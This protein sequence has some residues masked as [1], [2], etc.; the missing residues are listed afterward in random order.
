MKANLVPCRH[1]QRRFAPDRVRVHERACK[2]DRKPPT[3]TR[4]DQDDIRMRGK[5]FK[6]PASYIFSSLLNVDPIIIADFGV[7]FA[8]N[9]GQF[10]RVVISVIL[11]LCTSAAARGPQTSSSM[12]DSSLPRS[13]GTEMSRSMPATMTTRQQQRVPKFV[14]CYICGRQ[15]TDASLPIHEPQCLKKW[16]VQ[17][18]KLPRSE[19]RPPP[20][21]PDVLGET[22]NVT[23]LMVQL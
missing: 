4:D 18:N 6:W 2:G 11:C 9:P 5:Y 3:T 12:P 13:R 22:T 23:R 21:K 17:N 20:K 1:C 14:F 7:T 16:E 15:F 8:N 10:R 19:R